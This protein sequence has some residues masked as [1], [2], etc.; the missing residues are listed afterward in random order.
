MLNCLHQ[1]LSSLNITDTFIFCLKSLRDQRPHLF[2]EMLVRRQELR[3][4][5]GQ[6]PILRKDLSKQSID[7]GLNAKVRDCQA[8]TERA[9]G[10]ITTCDRRAVVLDS[11]AAE[12]KTLMKDGLREPAGTLH[13]LESDPFFSL[14]AGH[15]LNPVDKQ[16]LPVYKALSVVS[17]R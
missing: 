10:M 14:E 7:Q 16:Y 2:Q 8:S 17:E 13:R 12:C 3:R 5:L 9:Q 1:V 11:Y 15:Q 4:F 6:N